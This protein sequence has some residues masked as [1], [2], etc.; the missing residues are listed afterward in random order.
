MYLQEGMKTGEHSNY[1]TDMISVQNHN[2]ELGMKKRAR[3]IMMKLIRPQPV[4]RI[5]KTQW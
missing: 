5:I 4:A 2:N 1:H 3:T